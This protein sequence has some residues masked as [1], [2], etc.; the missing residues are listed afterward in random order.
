MEIKVQKML[1]IEYGDVCY[2]T[3][4][5]YSS[6]WFD[7]HLMHLIPLSKL[8]CI[9]LITIILFALIFLLC[10]IAISTIY[11]VLTQLDHKQLPY[12][13][14]HT[15]TKPTIRTT[16]LS[17]SFAFASSLSSSTL[18][19]LGHRCLRLRL[20]L[21]VIAVFVSSAVLDPAIKEHHGLATQKR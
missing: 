12:F 8:A 10:K 4:A 19:P 6:L 14:L 11:S 17:S 7:H 2:L 1:T 9:G 20:L 16:A 13:P 15:G 5:E 21:C 18:S 3:C